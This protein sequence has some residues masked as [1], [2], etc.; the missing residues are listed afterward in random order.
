MEKDNFPLEH[1]DF[2]ENNPHPTVYVNYSDIITS[3]YLNKEDIT[4]LW[5][6]PIT[7]A[8]QAL[9]GYLNYATFNRRNNYYKKIA[10]ALKAYKN[11]KE[12][13][14]EIKDCKLVWEG[15]RNIAQYS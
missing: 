3:I 6:I 7:Y 12:A 13:L 4:F 8:S 1:Q 15:R 10:S 11:C 5:F 2:N 14:R 9:V